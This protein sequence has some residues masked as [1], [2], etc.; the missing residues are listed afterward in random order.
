MLLVWQRGH[1]PIGGFPDA[2]RTICPKTFVRVS[3][4]AGVSGD[5]G[6]PLADTAS[7]TVYHKTSAGRRLAQASI[8]HRSCDLFGSY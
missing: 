2:A 1:R 5:V 6:E 8:R 3:V 4:V 7:R